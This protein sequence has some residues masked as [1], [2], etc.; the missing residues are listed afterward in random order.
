MTASEL[1]L[2]RAWQGTCPEGSLRDYFANSVAHRINEEHQSQPVC[3]GEAELVE[4][5]VDRCDAIFAE[6]NPEDSEA[7]AK[8]AEE[9]DTTDLWENVGE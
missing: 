6:H 5:F 8:L 2:R 9:I 4:D 3:W 7:A 1:H